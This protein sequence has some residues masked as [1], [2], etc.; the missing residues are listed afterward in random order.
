MGDKAL[1]AAD[2]VVCPV[3][4]FAIAIAVPFHT[5]VAI[6]PTAVKLDVTMAAGNAVPAR[7]AAGNPVVLVNVPLVGVPNIGVTNVGDVANTKEPE[8]VSS[9]TADAKLALVGVAKNVA[10]PVPKPDTP[11]DMGKPVA[12]VKVALV[13]VPS[14]GVTKVGLVDKT[15]LP[16]PVLVVTP[17]PPL[18][19]GNVPVTCV[20]KL[21]VPE[22][23]LPG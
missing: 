12:F 6:V 20:V 17:V 7:L 18:A 1:N 2:L 4:P 13:G 5:P 16:D 9:L 8:P 22:I 21:I 23:A 3:P 19:T 10:T 11:V 15:T 14:I